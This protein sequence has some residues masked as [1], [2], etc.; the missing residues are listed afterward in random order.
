MLHHFNPLRAPLLLCLSLVI[1]ATAGCIPE[2]QWL[3]DSSGFVYGFGKDDTSLE[4]RFYD[5]AKRA[6]HVVWSGSNQ[7]GFAVDSA[8]QVLYL[9]EPKR[10]T[11]KPPFS[12][13][14]SA[15]GI[16]TK[17]VLRSTRW[18]TW[19]GNDPDASVLSLI[20]LP[21]RPSNFLVKDKGQ[22]HC[23]R[24]AILNA[25]DES[26]IDVPEL[27]LDVIPDGSGFL[28][29]T[30]SVMATWDMSLNTK[31]KLDANAIKKLC[32]ESLWFV[33]LKG[34]RHPMTWDESALR[35][36]VA[37]YNG[38]LRTSERT[39]KPEKETYTGFLS[40][41]RSSWQGQR[42]GTGQNLGSDTLTLL[43]GHEHGATQIDIKRRTVTD[44]PGVNVALSEK[45][46]GLSPSLD[47][48]PSILLLKLKHVEYRIN[49]LEKSATTTSHYVASLEARWPV[50]GKA[51][52]IL[53]RADIVSLSIF[54]KASPNGLYAVLKYEEPDKDK[55]A[56]GSRIRYL[57]VDDAG[58]IV[59]RLFFRQFDR[60]DVNVEPWT[61]DD[62][63]NKPK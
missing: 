22:S 1:L 51:K 2:E 26:L 12:Y 10:G 7:V 30:R 5:V 8:K 31:E 45:Y 54:T 33:D 48:G 40:D 50:A 3:D 14:L 16:K 52:A 58:N 39:A 13:R 34:A 63:P 53:N 56:M 43:L 41:D 46:A 18:M 38:L 27:D 55:N 62:V 29:R 11:G 44:V 57:I 32:R 36:A 15:Y 49:I 37:R 19:N 28:A 24:N 60:L 6:E 9:I 17:T 42:A 59:D 61:R 21:N 47:S 25:D 20:E 4:I 23:E 35:R